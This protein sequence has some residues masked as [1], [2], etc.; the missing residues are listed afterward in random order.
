LNFFNKKNQNKNIFS[1]FKARNRNKE[2]IE[3]KIDKDP[4][5]NVDRRDSTKKPKGGSKT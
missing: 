2:K 3:N 4:K 1:F 5:P